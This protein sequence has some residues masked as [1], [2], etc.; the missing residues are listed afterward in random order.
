M[1]AIGDHVMVDVTKHLK[2]EEPKEITTAAGIIII[3]KDRQ[4]DKSNLI[5]GTVHSISNDISKKTGLQK[6][7]VVLISRLFGSKY[8]E[9]GKIYAMINYMSIFAKK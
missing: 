7:D 8:E 6:G 2:Q 4:I 3:E 1:K 5:D 9:G